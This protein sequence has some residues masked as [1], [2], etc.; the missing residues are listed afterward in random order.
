M[1]RPQRGSRAMSTIGANVQ[2]TPTLRASA[3][4]IAASRSA[5]CGSQLAAPPSGIGKIVR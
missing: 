2:C 5:N 4:A 3:A 1:M